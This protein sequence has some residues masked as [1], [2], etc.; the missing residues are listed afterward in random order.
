[1][2][3]TIGIYSFCSRVNDRTGAI[4]KGGGLRSRS[5]RF[6]TTNLF[7]RLFWVPFFELQGIALPPLRYMP[8]DFPAVGRVSLFPARGGFPRPVVWLVCLCVS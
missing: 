1:M 6:G 4:I 2:H 7:V 8:C 3:Y 5:T